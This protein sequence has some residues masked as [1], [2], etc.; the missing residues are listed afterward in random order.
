MEMIKRIMY[1]VLLSVFVLALLC[2][3][4]S[5]EEMVIDEVIADG[6]TYRVVRSG[7]DYYIIPHE[8]YTGSTDYEDFY[9]TASIKGSLYAYDSVYPLIE[10]IL[11]N[12]IDF[13]DIQ[14]QR[15]RN[16]L[17]NNAPLK[18][19]D[20]KNVYKPVF[21]AEHNITTVAWYGA[22]YSYNATLTDDTAKHVSIVIHCPESFTQKV[23]AFYAYYRN[24][25]EEGFTETETEDRNATIYRGEKEMYILYTLTAAEKTAQVVERYRIADEGSLH[26]SDTV[27]QEVNMF[28][29][30]GD[31]YYGVGVSGIDRRP[32]EEWL[33]S[34]GIEKDTPEE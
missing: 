12:K 9:K 10:D 2:G 7:E 3:C 28:V 25:F 11:E 1:C 22:D 6:E 15:W 8:Q 27:P 30:E 24:I 26:V 32:S 31:L 20:I 16:R 4:S 13:S 17:E 19:F 18:I 23:D 14:F 5:E 34:F 33:L 29:T 21:P